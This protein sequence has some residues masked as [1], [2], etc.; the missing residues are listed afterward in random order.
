MND[1][2]RLQNETINQ[3][4]E[5][6]GDPA[7]Y[8]AQ[9]WLNETYGGIANWV[10]LVEDGLTGHGTMAGLIRALQHELHT[11][12]DGQ[13][14]AGTEAAFESYYVA[15]G[16]YLQLA[17]GVNSNMNDIVKAALWCK[18]YSGHSTYSYNG[19]IDE[20]TLSG[21]A[22]LKLDAGIQAVVPQDRISAKLMKSLLSMDQFVLVESAGGKSQIREIQQY[23]NANFG[24]Y[25]G[26][27]PCDGIYQRSM[28]EALI[29]RLQYIEGQ[30]GSAVD[31][32][33]GSGTQS[34]LPI[35]N[36]SNHPAEAVRLFNFCL[37]CNG[38]NSSGTAWTANVK[39][40]IRAF[41]DQ[42]MLEVNGTGDVDTWMA[43]LL[44]KGNP[45]REAKACDCATIL[46]RAKANALFAA[47]YRYVG[48]YV[49]GTVGSGT[50]ER[51]KALTKDEMN[52]IFEAGL[53]LFAIYQEGGT[54]LERYTYDLGKQDA[55]KAI[56]AAKSLYIPIR[57]Y[58]YF[59]VD[60][61]VL[62]G[63]IAGYVKEYFRGINE[64]MKANDNIYL[65][66]IYGSRNVCN[67]ICSEFHLAT[68][69]F[70]G[71][72][73][74]GYSGNMGF[75]LPSCWAFDQFH[76]YNFNPGP[77][78]NFPIDKVAVSGR[79]SG[80]SSFGGY[81]SEVQIVS[82]S[83]MKE[84]AAKIVDSLFEFIDADNNGK[85]TTSNGTIS[86]PFS[87]SGVSW[88]E[89]LTIPLGAG[90]RAEISMEHSTM[91]DLNEDNVSYTTAKITNG[92]SP[93][94]NSSYTLADDLFD[95][96]DASLSV[97]TDLELDKN[98]LSL[99]SEMSAEIDNGK[100]SFGFGFGTNTASIFVVI[101]SYLGVG[102]NICNSVSIKFELIT[103]TG[104]NAEEKVRI[105]NYV[106][107]EDKVAA[108]VC[109]LT[110]TIVMIGITIGSA[111]TATGAVAAAMGLVLSTTSDWGYDTYE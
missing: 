24:D 23:L 87:Q 7:V 11:G 101:E 45:N 67:R 57:E 89:T 64:I 78:I 34:L 79:Y 4:Q 77:S 70:V 28:N 2:I 8:Y 71:D 46:D 85:I 1:R 84:E 72:M 103:E 73:A 62:D 102:F 18:G 55:T 42:Y 22:K 29:K 108:Y 63:Y 76:E 9:R 83:Q 39:A 44:S 111:G 68:S 92:S 94:F 106:K 54:Y 93:I 107:S 43:L 90:I 65:V 32:I 97:S 12:V 69:C 88:E 15:T 36:D 16:G 100:I 51:S 82:E 60:F 50:S 49:S 20:V 40:N 98:G 110:V 41:Q 52:D 61:D 35:L 96:I 37:T 30:R 81:N 74:T 99:L 59:A 26:I 10:S 66:G 48:R 91:F 109:A 47:G 6:P 17:I 14:G 56:A 75:Q 33:F 19:L 86:L 105:N 53:K 27:I 38:Y 58:I 5:V 25:V 31:G 3:T 104:N 13:F 80:F 95:A 21:V